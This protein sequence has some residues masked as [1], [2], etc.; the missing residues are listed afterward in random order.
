MRA[1]SITTSEARDIIV[2]ESLSKLTAAALYDDYALDDYYAS[3]MFLGPPGVGKSGVQFL[4]ARDIADILSTIRNKKVEAVKVSMRISSDEAAR[5]VEKVI[6]GEAVPYLHLYLPQTKIWHLE[7][8]PSPQDN[9]VEVAGR[10]IPYNLWRLDPFLLPLLDYREL[11]KPDQLVTPILVIDEFNMGRKD[12]REALFQLAR[13]A[14]LGKAKLNPLTI[15]SLVGNTPETNVYAEEELPAPL[16]NRAIRFIVDK[17]D[18][19][20]WV[21]FMNEVYRT[22]WDHAVGG[23]LMSNRQYLYYVPKEDPEVVVT[24]RTWTHLATRLYLAKIMF[25][26][27]NWDVSTK[28]A[29][30]NKYMR[31]VVYGLLPGTLADEF[32][33]YYTTVIR[34]SV[35]EVIKKPKM[36]ENMEPN[37]AAYMTLVATSQLLEEYRKTPPMMRDL[38]IKKMRDIAVH[39]SNKLGAEGIGIVL[40]SLPA[41]IRIKLASLMPNDVKLKARQIAKQIQAYEEAI[42]I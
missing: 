8:T 6:R 10:K 42:N 14:E 3:L 28:R 32:I 19:S 2:L 26:R 17:P 33:A 4:A 37:V 9:Y 24:P 39:A 1:L 31:Y 35:S 27:F 38:I 29:K 16:V 12:V 23:F 13:S 11:T 7:G 21:A 40:N 5:I 20:G 25:N 15:I 22:K 36:L 34:I 18:L 41:P 30:F